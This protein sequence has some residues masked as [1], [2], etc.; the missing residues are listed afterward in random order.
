MLKKMRKKKNELRA[1]N[2]QPE[3]STGKMQP[4]F[5]AGKHYCSC[6]YKLE[7]MQPVLKEGKLGTSAK[8]WKTYSWW[9]AREKMQLVLSVGKHAQ[10]V[11][12]AQYATLA[13]D[14]PRF[15][16]RN[17]FPWILLHEMNPWILLHAW[18][19]MRFGKAI[20]L[21]K[22]LTMNWRCP[23]QKYSQITL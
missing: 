10:M 11:T 2:M 13:F 1:R 15:Q 6:C 5:S 12:A 9:K 16:L 20:L 3:L 4:V 14:F 18:Q 8:S 7:T 21:H 23:W 19:G 17:D 22:L